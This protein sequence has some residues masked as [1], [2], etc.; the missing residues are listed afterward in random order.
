[1]T[2]S[3]LSLSRLTRTRS[4]RP[5]GFQ[6]SSEASFSRFPS[7]LRWPG[8]FRYNDPIGPLEIKK[9]P[10]HYVMIT[11]YYLHL[12]RV[13][14]DPSS[15]HKHIPKMLR[16]SFSQH[17]SCVDHFDLVIALNVLQSLIKCVD[18]EG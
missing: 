16:I 5:W 1:M 3:S 4:L 6:T 18:E 17:P 13:Y 15:Y 10:L 2:C 8:S 14:Y 9:G 11:F 7:R 12:R